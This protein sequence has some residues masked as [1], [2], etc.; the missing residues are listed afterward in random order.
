MKNDPGF[1]SQVGLVRGRYRLQRAWKTANQKQRP[2]IP[3][4]RPLLQ[5]RCG[6][7]TSVKS[8]KFVI[9]YRSEQVCDVK[10]GFNSAAGRAGIPD[11]TSHTLRHTAGTWMAQRGGSARE[12]ASYLG[13]SGQR[14]AE[15]YYTITA[16]TSCKDAAGVQAIR[17]EVLR[18]IV[19]HGLLFPA[20]NS[21]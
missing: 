13:H 18:H 11:C 1:D 16:P 3:I 21:Q 9:A 12:I 20:R 17:N 6:V 7:L 10:T 2:I 8:S 14:T 5:A 15:L 19:G 4:P